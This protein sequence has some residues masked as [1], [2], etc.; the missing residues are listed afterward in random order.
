[1]RHHGVE[2]LTGI[3]TPKEGTGELGPLCI[4]AESSSEHT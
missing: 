1:M 2:V 4:L 3:G